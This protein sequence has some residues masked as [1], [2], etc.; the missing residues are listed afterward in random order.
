LS[1]IW[2]KDLKIV[3]KKCG[4]TLDTIGSILNKMQN[5]TCENGDLPNLEFLSHIHIQCLNCGEI[6]GTVYLSMDND[7][8]EYAELKGVPT[9]PTTNTTLRRR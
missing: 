8:K 5:M 7:L 4:A 9:R 2:L 6:H 1:K 3:C